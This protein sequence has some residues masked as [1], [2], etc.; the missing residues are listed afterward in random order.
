MVLCYLFVGGVSFDDEAEMEVELSM[1]AEEQLQYSLDSLRDDV[2]KQH[3]ATQP[4]P[5]AKSCTFFLISFLL[6]AFLLPPP[7]R[8][9][10]CEYNMLQ[11]YFTRYQHH[12]IT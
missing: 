1:S 5:A 12:N 10:V 9:S 8:L 3:T 7:G 4:P 6:G 11:C 2:I